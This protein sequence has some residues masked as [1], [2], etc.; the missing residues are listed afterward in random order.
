MQVSRRNF[1][2]GLSAAGAIALS[3]IAGEM[4][5]GAAEK[6]SSTAVARILFNENPLGPSSKALEAVQSAF[7]SL[8]R[9]PLG[10]GPLLETKLRKMHG[11]PYN[12]PASGLSLR[13]TPPPAGDNDLLL[14]VGSSEILKAIAWAYC[15]EGGNVVEAYPGY[16]AVG[17]EAVGMPNSR[18]TRRLV[19]L[20]AA[21]RIDVKAMRQAIDAGTRIVVVCNPNNPTGSTLS[22]GEIEQLADITPASGLLLVDEAYIEFL[23]DQAPVSAVELAKTR[24]NVLVT[25]T[26]SK[27]YG[28]A[29]L[30]IGYGLG[31]SS[32][33]ERLRP[34]M[35]GR[36]S[37]S[38]AG[39]LAAGAAIEDEEHVLA[40]RKLNQSIQAT[41]MREF[42]RF[43]WKMTASDTC[44]AWVDVGQD[45]SKLVQYLADRNVLISGGQRWDLPNCVRISIGTEEENERLLSGIASFM[46]A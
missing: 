15:S 39:V 40:T 14:G 37:L 13:P 34:Y 1:V 35:L 7:S 25:R 29:G 46:S 6:S 36:L 20:D 22:I 8:S 27:I 3:G 24:K 4:R 23:E 19:P 9:Y 45:C 16:S 41:W 17:A 32:V 11:L 10:E 28:L 21:N 44:F 12:E 33:V 5:T 2:S 18:A 26:F 42:P 30:R 43:G 31:N 38:M